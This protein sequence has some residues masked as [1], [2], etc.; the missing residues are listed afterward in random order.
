EMLTLTSKRARMGLPREF[1][2]QHPKK[3][4]NGCSGSECGPGSGRAQCVAESIRLTGTSSWPP[5]LDNQLIVHTAEI[6]Y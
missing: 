1:R 4:K 6:S 5:T 3:M 2:K